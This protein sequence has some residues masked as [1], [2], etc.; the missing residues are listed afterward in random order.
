MCRVLDGKQ[1]LDLIKQSEDQPETLSM[2]NGECIYKDNS[3][4]NRHDTLLVKPDCR[5]L[6]LTQLVANKGSI[7]NMNNK[8]QKRKYPNN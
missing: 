1:N 2:K 5:K 7:P 6:D 3:W 4:I 8:S